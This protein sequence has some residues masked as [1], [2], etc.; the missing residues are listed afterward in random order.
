MIPKIN[1]TVFF[2]IYFFIFFKLKCMKRRDNK[3]WLCAQRAAGCTCEGVR[4]RNVE[5]DGSGGVVQEILS[6][7]HFCDKALQ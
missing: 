2:F 1:H 4:T 3:A 6:I 5:G 7:N